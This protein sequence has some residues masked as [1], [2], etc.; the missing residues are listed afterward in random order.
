MTEKTKN[1]VTKIARDFVKRTNANL[2]EQQDPVVKKAMDELQL[3]SCL[4]GASE[5]AEWCEVFDVFLQALVK[6]PNIIFNPD[7]KKELITVQKEYK[8][9]LEE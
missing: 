3:S 1:K 7:F 5:W 4:R 6:T 2:K 9:F 8:L